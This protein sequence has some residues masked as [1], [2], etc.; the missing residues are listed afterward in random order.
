MAGPLLAYHG[1]ARGR[2]IGGL[3]EWIV[4]DGSVYALMRMTRRRRRWALRA[5]ARSLSRRV[6]WGLVVAVILYGTL[7]RGC[8]LGEAPLWT[9]EAETSINALT[10]LAEGVP[11]SQYLGQPIYENT[12]TEPWPE[13]PEYE[14]RDSSYSNRGLA[15]YH[16][17]LP[18]YATALS[19]W[20]HGIE[21]DVAPAA[22]HIPRSVDDM[23][24]RTVAAR[25]PGVV[26]GVVFLLAIFLAAR[27]IYGT[28]A[29]WAALA[30]A[31]IS[32][33]AVTLARQARYYSATLALTAVAAFL[34]ACMV[35]RGRRRDFATGGV[36]LALLFHTNL[37]ALAGIA[38]AFASSAHLLLRQEKIGTKLL[39]L[40]GPFLAGVV[41]WVLV[42][43]FLDSAASLPAARTLLTAEEI[44]LYLWE[45][46]PFVVV[47]AATLA[48][49][50]WIQVFRAR[51]PER[52]RRPFV[53]SRRVLIVLAGWTA[54]AFA[55]FNLLVPAASYFYSRLSLILLVPALLFG[56]TLFAAAARAITRHHSPLLAS[57]L[58]V[59]L[60]ASAGKAIAWWP[61]TDGAKPPLF[62][63]VEHLQ[64]IRLKPG[65]R[66]YGDTGSALPLVFYSGLPVQN[67]MPIRRAFLET[68]PG[69]LII[70]EA[71]P[72]VS[73]SGR[74]VHDGLAARA[75][76]V[77][78]GESWHLARRVYQHALAARLRR[79]AAVVA[80]ALPPEPPSFAELQR[81]QAA[82]TRDEMATLIA[83][84]GNP[85]FR[86]FQYDTLTEMWQVFFYRFV[87]PAAHMGPRLNYAPRVPGATA[88]ILRGGWVVLHS[89][90]PA[91][92]A[93]D[94]P[95]EGP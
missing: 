82:T 24:R 30:A 81:L 73:L 93:A 33:S 89:P 42:T 46:R 35:R 47:A 62:E 72:M 53:H 10:I 48:W 78:D 83:D 66:V 84:Y 14:F 26:F 38:A 31:T 5:R 67:V 95:R 57:A 28:D 19:F 79:R 36:V 65:T 71:P 11:V 68:Y 80:T 8:R 37:L 51:V 54:G 21:P 63:L 4:P 2:A 40:A 22:P 59:L 45:R 13:H 7:L 23:Y 75:I 17:W 76:H 85:M 1:V 58:L 18:L 6:H 20:L 92:A 86:G 41:P 52:V 87:D 16:G 49:L 64:S 9:D 27:E 44:G 32:T 43:G 39:L 91:T 3:I 70:V 77:D 12:L 90:P 94:L 69:D 88:A 55:A 61:P 60:L 34:L 50:T 74:D 15:I 56:A 29:G 25:L